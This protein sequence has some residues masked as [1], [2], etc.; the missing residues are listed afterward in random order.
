MPE[1]V[2]VYYFVEQI[3]KKIGNAIIRNIM[4]KSGK[5]SRKSPEGYNKIMTL[6]PLKIIGYGTKGKFIYIKRSTFEY[7]LLPLGF[8]HWTADALN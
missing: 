7:G 6:L 1:L 4:I 5:Y 8:T 2:E 3:K